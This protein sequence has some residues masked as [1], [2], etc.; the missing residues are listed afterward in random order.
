MTRW[1]KI[2]DEHKKNFPEAAPHVQS[3]LVVARTERDALINAGPP[4]SDSEA[5]L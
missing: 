3:Q 5:A 4:D 1:E 2:L